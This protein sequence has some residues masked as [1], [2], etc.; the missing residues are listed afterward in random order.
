M[1]FLLIILSAI[2]ILFLPGFVVSQ[3][4]FRRKKIEILERFAL[5]FAL[6][7]TL[8]PLLVFYTNLLGIR[9]SRVSVML[10]VLEILLISILI[11]LLQNWR[12]EK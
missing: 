9:I 11:L 6:S 8:V 12:N 7:I 4:F 5:S 1:Q 3:I 2:T 10:N